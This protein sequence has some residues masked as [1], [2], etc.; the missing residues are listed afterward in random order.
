MVI[1]IAIPLIITTT[2]WTL[3]IDGVQCILH[4]FSFFSPAYLPMRQVLC[5]PYFSEKKAT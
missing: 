5:Y 1:I 3:I 2:Y 4:M